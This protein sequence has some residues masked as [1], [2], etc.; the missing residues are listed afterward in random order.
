MNNLVNS[1]YSGM[2]DM[3]GNVWEWTSTVY[4]VD[5]Q[6]RQPQYTLRGGSYIDSI[7]GKFNHKADV[8]TR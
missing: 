4:G 7:D 8:T 2:Y 3:V 1:P 6:T 5:K